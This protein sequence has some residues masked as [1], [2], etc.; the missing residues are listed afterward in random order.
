MTKWREG[1]EPL[2][3]VIGEN[4]AIWLSTASMSRRRS[5]ADWERQ[6]GHRWTYWYRRGFRCLKCIIRYRMAK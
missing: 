3:F 6:S 5:I 1:G 2:W 4:G